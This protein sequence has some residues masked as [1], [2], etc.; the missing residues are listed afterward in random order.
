MSACRAKH[1]NPDIP[2]QDW[3]CPKCG[4]DDFGQYDFLE[5]QSDECPKTHAQAYY[6]CNGCGYSASGTTVARN[7]AKR[8]SLVR[9]E[10][11]KGAGYV[12]GQK[13]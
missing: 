5:G 4:D 7:F 10:A 2:E 11:C 12:S 6:G 9:C 1:A 8:K 3:C 13:S